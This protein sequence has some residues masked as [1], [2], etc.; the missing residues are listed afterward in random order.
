MI[1]S[2]KQTLCCDEAN[3]GFCPQVTRWRAQHPRQ[4]PPSSSRLCLWV[5]IWRPTPPM[6]VIPLSLWQPATP[7]DTAF[8]SWAASSWGQNSRSWWRIHTTLLLFRETAPDWLADNWENHEKVGG[9]VGL[10]PSKTKQNGVNAPCCCWW[11]LSNC[12]QFL[13]IP[14]GLWKTQLEV[15][16]DSPVGL[17]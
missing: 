2:H 1:T 9:L 10:F 8:S 6:R 5:R 13:Y 16:S 4:W 7:M 11:M 3:G 17:K 12:L 15:I 14:D